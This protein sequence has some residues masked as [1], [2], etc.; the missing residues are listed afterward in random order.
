MANVTIEDEQ[1]LR[2]EIVALLETVPLAG[3]VFGRRRKFNSRND[4][5]ERVGSTLGTGNAKTREIRFIEVELINLEDSDEGFAECPVPVLT[6]NLHVFHEFNDKRPDGSNSD[7]DFTAMLLELRRL[8]SARRQFLDRRA[9][10]DPSI[11]PPDA[12]EFTQFGAD[13]VADVWGHSKDLTLKVFIYD[14]P[15]P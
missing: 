14:E 12:T 2:G 4:F 3:N 7:R 8:F 9:C 15:Q 10:V 13:T 1:A 6:Y 5:L 11:M